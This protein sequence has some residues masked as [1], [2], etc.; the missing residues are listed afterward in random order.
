MPKTIKLEQIGRLE[1]IP[2]VLGVNYFTLLAE[3]HVI[4]V[5]L[6]FWQIL[7]IDPG[8]IV[9]TNAHFLRQMAFWGENK[10]TIQ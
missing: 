5:Y 2:S 1:Y 6:A 4:R 10:L 3:L 7:A 8:R 9:V